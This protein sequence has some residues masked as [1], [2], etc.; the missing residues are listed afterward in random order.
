MTNSQSKELSFN[1][2]YFKRT[3]EIALIINTLIDNID[4][5]KKI[6]TEFK[7]I[8]FNLYK[9]I[10]I[11]RYANFPYSIY[12]SYNRRG[13]KYIINYKTRDL[14]MT[15]VEKPF[16]GTS[17][18]VSWNNYD[19]SSAFLTIHYKYINSKKTNGY[20]NH[21]EL[22]ED[23]YEIGINRYKLNLSIKLIN[24]CR[25]LRKESDLSLKEALFVL[26]NNYLFLSEY[27]LYSIILEFKKPVSER[28]DFSD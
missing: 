16:N 4:L 7:N 5:T 26:N 25:F 11:E 8:E 6:I 22:P 19:H 17:K 13:K 10:Y 23:V 14:I 9:S 21:P 12:D 2:N 3:Q 20:I 24:Y 15:F 1:P 18:K 27:N 28:I